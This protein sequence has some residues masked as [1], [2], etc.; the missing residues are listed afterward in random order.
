MRR[1]GS[2]SGREP[3]E[4]LP[5]DVTPCGVGPHRGDAISE[6]RG[7][8][9]DRAC[10]HQRDVRRRHPRRSR[11]ADCHRAWPAAEPWTSGPRRYCRTGPD[12]PLPDDCAQ[13][14]LET[15]NAA[16]KMIALARLPLEVPVD[17]MVCRL[18]QT[19]ASEGPVTVSNSLTKAR[20]WCLPPQPARALTENNQ[21]HTSA[22]VSGCKTAT[23]VPSDARPTL[24]PRL[25]ILP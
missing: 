10:R 5:G 18:P 8:L 20:F 11:A 2:K 23:N 13:V 21:H 1:S 6:I 7:C 16:A 15:N 19:P 14:W 9:A 17:R 22:F 24:V 12:N 3:L 25:P 4:I